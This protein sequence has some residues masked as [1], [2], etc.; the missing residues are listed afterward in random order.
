MKKLLLLKTVRGKLY[1][2]VISICFFAMLTTFAFVFANLWGLYRD[3]LNKDINS[4]S[5][6]I[7]DNSTAA[8]L[9]EDVQTLETTLQSL[10]RKNNVVKASIFRKNGQLLASYERPGHLTY[11]DLTGWK[12]LGL[13]LL[14]P[15]ID[16]KLDVVEPIILDNETIGTLFL[17]ASTQVFKLAM[18]EIGGIIFIS[19]LGGMII[20]IILVG[21]LQGALTKPVQLLID[22]MQS[23]T[24]NNDYSLRVKQISHD[25]IGILAV[26]FNNMLKRIQIRDDIL[27]DQVQERTRQLQH[28]MDKAVKLANEAQSAN[29]AKSQFLANM[30]HEIRTPM[31]GVLGM[32]ELILD[33]DVT[34]EQRSALET[35]RTSGESLLTIINDI[36]DFSKIEAGKLDIENI[37]FNLPVLIDDIVQM[38][39]HRAHS[40]GLELIVELDKDLPESIQAD[41]SRVRQILTNLLSNAIKFTHRGEVHLKAL[42]A[43][44]THNQFELCFEVRD[45]GIGLEQHEIDKLFQP[46]TQADE[47]TTR[48]FGGTGLGLAISRQLAELMG[49][50][51]NC[52]SEK[53]KGSTF[54]CT[55]QSQQVANQPT[56]T[57]KIDMLKG[58][59]GLIIDDN[60]TNRT[61]LE[62][63]LSGCGAMTVSAEDGLSGLDM[64]YKAQKQQQPF[65]FLILDMNMPKM[66]G[67]EVATIIRKD[68]LYSDLKIL[69]LT[70]VS[71]HKN[72]EKAK[73][74]GI[75]KCLTKPIR[76]ID[77]F[78]SIQE[79]ISGREAPSVTNYALDE[80]PQ[81][82]KEILLVEDNLINQQVA[83]GILKKLGCFVSLAGNGKEAI[84]SL[85]DRSFDL[86]FMDCQMPVVDGYQAT[87]EIRQQEKNR[88]IPIIALTANALSGDREKCLNAG[89]NDY[90][91]KPFSQSQVTSV[92]EKW[93]GPPQIVN[94]Q[95][96]KGASMD[97]EGLEVINHRALDNI[98]AL[99]GE[100]NED[101]LSQIVEIFLNDM[102]EQLERLHKA[103][104]SQ[105]YNA[106]RSIAHSMKSASANL[107][108]LRVSA[109]FKELEAAGRDQK[110]EV[111]PELLNK[112]K[113]EF[114]IL[115]PILT[116]LITAP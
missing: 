43:K 9:F 115:K 32:A 63:Q 72:N 40:K 87:M 114:H 42:K 16:D 22:T 5:T 104:E 53:G 65:D 94:K 18:L 25:E 113:D 39:A 76:Q 59:K 79:L 99:A 2:I 96:I 68:A 38:L 100:G 24:Q 90:L 80:L 75:N 66:D 30:S 1:A 109:I 58:T 107:G 11:E 67:L 69:M 12:K 108:A 103:Q 10:E 26:G 20:A 46:F 55:I 23:V 83:K 21:W 84:Q 92:L 74:I 27:E 106:I 57:Y 78:N 86:I 33:T 101:L 97:F 36:L 29:K 88:G 17:Q 51:I 81:F 116:K 37:N 61:V 110:T 14:D 31:N 70:S 64:L 7:A 49:G 89:M 112:L 28:A 52:R 4:L 54:W 60:N 56:Y 62:H 45:T 98:R 48:K 35:I 19:I 3:N 71:M 6:I 93:L 15:L 85:Q 111:I 82:K 47:S 73:E 91:T 105:E 8:L 41:P 102:P 95:L 34:N 44:S 13:K 77:L 50:T